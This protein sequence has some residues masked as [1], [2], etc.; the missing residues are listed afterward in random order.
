MEKVAIKKLVEVGRLLYREGLVDARA[1]NLSVRLKDQLIITRRGSHLGRLE[2]WDF[3]ELP[4]EKAH[5]LEDRASSEL[6]VHREIYLQ[7]SHRAVVHAHPLATTILSLEMDHIEP[8]DSEGRDLLGRVEVI[9]N[10]PSGS[11]E[12]AKA[13]ASS[14]KA[15]RLVVV[16]AH[17]VFSADLDPFYAYAH[18]SVLERSCKILLHERGNIQRL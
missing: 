13:V 17:G 5:I 16:R 3:V 14:L 12:L 7:T 4:L 8:I 11:Y 1:G 10:Y 15:S 6:V 2:G 18:I 9:P